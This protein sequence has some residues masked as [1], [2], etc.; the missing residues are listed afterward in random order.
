MINN[1]D[2]WRPYSK[3]TTLQASLIGVASFILSVVIED[4]VA[5]GKGKLVFTGLFVLTAILVTFREHLDQFNVI[6]CVII[7]TIFHIAVVILSPWNDSG[8]AGAIFVPFGLL[9]YSLVFIVLSR[10]INR[11]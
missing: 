5:P 8:Y 4:T 1:D 10:T 6:I 7:M 2:E 3:I 11:T 9:E